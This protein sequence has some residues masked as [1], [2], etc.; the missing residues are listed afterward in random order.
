MFSDSRTTCRKP[1]FRATQLGVIANAELGVR[2]NAELGV[3]ANVRTLRK[4]RENVLKEFV[5]VLHVGVS[6]PNIV[7]CRYPST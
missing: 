3:I 1:N 4:I 5:L 7:M 6:N 2:A